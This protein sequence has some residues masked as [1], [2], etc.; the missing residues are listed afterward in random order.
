MLPNR[1]THHTWVRVY[2][3][4]QRDLETVDGINKFK[5]SVVLIGDGSAAFFMSVLELKSVKAN[6]FCLL[7]ISEVWLK[8]FKESD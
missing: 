3:W 4:V 1:T 6:D 8:V 5:S 7:N 2:C